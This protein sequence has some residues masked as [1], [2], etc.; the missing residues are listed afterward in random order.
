PRVLNLGESRTWGSLVLEYDQ[1]LEESTHFSR[2]SR[3]EGSDRSYLWSLWRSYAEQQ[4]QHFVKKD[5][6]RATEEKLAHDA[7]KNE[8]AVEQ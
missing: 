2:D 3:N 6:G 7:E 5:E 1:P 4:Q 8:A